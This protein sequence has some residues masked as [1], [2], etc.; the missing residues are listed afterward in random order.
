M[1][2]DADTAE[3]REA[4]ERHGCAV[5]FL[6]ERAMLRFMRSV[7]YEQ[8]ND[9]ALRARL[10]ATKGFC[11]THAHR[12][13]REAKSVLGTALIYQD[14]VTAALRDLDEPPPERGL[15]GRSKSKEAPRG[16]CQAC[17]FQHEAQDRYVDDLI[18]GLA[19][20]SIA[21]ALA[22]SDGL[23]FPHTKRAVRRGGSRADPIRARARS[24]AEAIVGN[25]SEVIRK[26]DYRFRHE[27]RTDAER[28]ATR[29]AVAWTAGIDGLV[30]P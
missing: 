11:T 6:S 22:G 12:W 8:V 26:E 27:P 21:A 10:R 18:A 29:R 14:M 24:V 20:P 9:P 25:L 7:A 13:L 1:P 5:C 15:F 30:S 23:C 3:L 19:D 4:I 2:S 28:S 17:R 16:S